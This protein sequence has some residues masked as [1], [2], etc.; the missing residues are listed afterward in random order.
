M[1]QLDLFP[2]EQ[3]TDEENRN[4]FTVSNGGVT[5]KKNN[6]KKT[7]HFIINSYSSQNLKSIHNLFFISILN[8]LIRYV[9]IT[10]MHK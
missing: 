10:K 1:Y 4:S 7:H 2:I 6:K 3:D 8:I 5:Q 9:K